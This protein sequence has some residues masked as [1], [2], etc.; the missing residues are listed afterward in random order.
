[1]SKEV[2]L[3]DKDVIRRDW[4]S[5]EYTEQWARSFAKKAEDAHKLFMATC[6]KSTDPDVRAAHTRYVEMAVIAAFMRTGK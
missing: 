2:E 3:D 6:A 5:H 1:M 4:L